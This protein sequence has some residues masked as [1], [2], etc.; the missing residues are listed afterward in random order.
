M[1]ERFQR[2][3][4][5][6]AAVSVAIA[7]AAQSVYNKQIPEYDFLSE[8]SEVAFLLGVFAS[9]GVFYLLFTLLINLHKILFWRFFDR[10]YY[11]DGKWNCTVLKTAGDPKTLYGTVTIEQKYNSIQF[12]AMH[13]I[14]KE[15]KDLW[16][17]WTSRNVFLVNGNIDVYWE[18][19]R[20]NGEVVTGKITF[21]VDGSKPPKI[22]D[23][24][25][26][27][28]QPSNTYGRMV[29]TRIE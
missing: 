12:S 26:R 24:I 10:R 2:Y 11:V 22:L 15:K 23:G 14:D 16:S 4:E 21:K 9:L 25:F 7:I 6:F 27:D 18:V 5:L 19:E 1:H 17:H 28:N 20:M 8:H 29:Y 3:Y 13:Y